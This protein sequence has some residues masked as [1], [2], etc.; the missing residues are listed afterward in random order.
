MATIEVGQEG[1][2]IQTTLTP[3]LQDNKPT[4]QSLDCLM[5]IVKT[6]K[7]GSCMADRY[8]IILETVT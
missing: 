4:R 5:T 2:G 1:E 7:I 3:P 8:E 6:D